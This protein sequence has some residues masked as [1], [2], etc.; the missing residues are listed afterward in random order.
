MKS[1][2]INEQFIYWREDCLMPDK[3]IYE[4]VIDDESG[5]SINLKAYV[6]PTQNDEGKRYRVLFDAA[7]AYQIVDESFRQ[8]TFDLHNEREGCFFF[9][10]NSQWLVRLNQESYGAY[11]DTNFKHYCII[12]L[13]E[14]IDVISEFVP[15]FE[16]IT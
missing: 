13:N 8:Q 6:I 1:G 14:V 12:T 15:E 16:E 2:S 5:L 9:V 7:I 4:G 3:V 10:E 11:E